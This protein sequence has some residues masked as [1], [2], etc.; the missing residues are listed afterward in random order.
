MLLYFAVC[1][2]PHKAEASV[3]VYLFFFSSPVL[4]YGVVSIGLAYVVSN[5][6]SVLEVRVIV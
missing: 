4:F 3:P 2:K 5:L 6:G 1:T